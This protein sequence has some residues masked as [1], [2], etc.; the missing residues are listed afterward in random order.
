MKQSQTQ[1]TI[2]CLLL[3]V[4]ATTTLS[5]CQFFVGL[6]RGV[7]RIFSPGG[8]GEDDRGFSMKAYSESV[9]PYVRTQ[10][11]SCHENG[12]PPQF[13]SGDLNQAHSVA[14]KKV[15]FDDIVSSRLY[16]RSKDGHC[17]KDFCR[18]DG[19]KMKEL[20][21]LWKVSSRPR[22][23][24]PGPDVAK[25]CASDSTVSPAD[26]R[27]LTKREYRESLK[28]LF[29][30]EAVKAVADAIATI[31]DEIIVG[32]FDNKDRTIS[33]ALVSGQIETAKALAEYM[34]DSANESLAVSRL[35]DIVGPCI[36]VPHACIDV[37]ISRTIGRRAYR[38]N[39][40]VDETTRLRSIYDQYGPTDWRKGYRGVIF[41]I[42]MSPQF[43]YRV[44][45]GESA[46]ANGVYPLTQFEIASRLSYLFW[47]TG[48]DDELLNLAEQKKLNSDEEMKLQ[49]DRLF[50]D[51]RAKTHLVDSF[52]FS[53]LKLNDK[54]DYTYNAEYLDGIDPS[55]LRTNVM[56]ETKELLRYYTW[57]KPSTL[58][59][60]LSSNQSFATTSNVAQLYGVKVWNPGDPAVYFPQGQRAGLLTRAAFVAGGKPGT[61]PFGMGNRIYRQIFCYEFQRPDP[62]AFPEGVLDPPLPD[63][64]QTQRQQLE[65][66]TKGPEC[67]LCHNKLNI[68]FIFE[69]YD[70]L[71]RVRAEEN[72]ITIDTSLNLTVVNPEREVFVKNA[73]ELSNFLAEHPGVYQ[74]FAKQYFRFAYG[75]EDATEDR[76]AI[77]K[78]YEALSQAGG[79]LAEGLKALATQ[80]QFRYL[81]VNNATD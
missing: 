71:G 1:K 35:R 42:L 73:V 80:T 47:G 52:Y 77:Q 43:L 6:A 70:A 79:T 60:L 13:A 78:G 45:L 24:D 20:I 14:V 38:R 67:Q 75:R 65:A 33:E 58:G 36:A 54:P 27:R 81:K 22:P 11:V 61:H 53:W 21:E 8:N 50:A 40:T 17:M 2:L 39:L 64:N 23:V 62:A 12:A 16:I 29:G 51:P 37:F 31:P 63:P 9:Y 46:G 59:T 28:A 5:G 48:P 49:V 25:S 72:N 74:C 56:N 41:A 10:C 4:T 7:S 32:G 15:N 57:T 34:T 30:D 68:G 26:L 69:G 44:E 18:T 19:V 66:A 55:N 3:M 76:C